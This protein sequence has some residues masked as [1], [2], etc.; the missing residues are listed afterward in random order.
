[1]QRHELILR[2]WLAAMALST[3]NALRIVLA[4]WP[5]FVASFPAA[6][7]AGGRVA[8]IA[9]P[10]A[11]LVAIFGLW[12]WRCWGV[13]LLLVAAPATLAF[14]LRARGPWLHALAALVSVAVTAALILWNRRRYGFTDGAPPPR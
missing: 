5:G 14:D 9:L 4:E 11:L 10:L 1:M 7:A 6:D 8:A 2:L 13:W 12:R 3:L